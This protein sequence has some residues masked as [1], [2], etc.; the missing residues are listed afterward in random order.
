[1]VADKVHIATTEKDYAWYRG[2]FR[3]QGYEF[4]RFEYPAE[5]WVNPKTGETHCL[6]LGF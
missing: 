1:M 2:V 3:T 6:V 4:V 5:K